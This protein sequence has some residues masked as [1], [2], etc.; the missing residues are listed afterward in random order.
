M[1]KVKKDLS[2][3]IFG[4]WKVIKQSDDFISGNKHYAGWLCEYQC[5]K[6]I[7]RN[8]LGKNLKNG[9]SK[10]CGCLQ[11]EKIKI[12]GNNNKKYNTYDLFGEYGIGYTTKGEPFYFDKEDYDLIKDYCWMIGN[13]GYVKTTLHNNNETS[14]LLFHRYIFKLDDKQNN[15]VDHI[16]HITIDNRKQNLRVVTNS[17]NCMNHKLKSNNTSGVTGVSYDLKS[18]KWHSRIG[19][20]NKEISLGFYDDFKEAVEVRK[21]AEEKYHGEYSYRNSTKE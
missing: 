10:S 15:F 9:K 2:N 1:V 5:E 19:I 11:K 18:N 8:V 13:D 7:I 20:N 14:T 16:N 4:L 21:K 17:Q 6:H 12:I 3:H